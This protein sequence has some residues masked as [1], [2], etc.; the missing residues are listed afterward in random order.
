MFAVQPFC[1]IAS[2]PVA[3][4]RVHGTRVIPEKETV[5]QLLKKFSPGN[6]I[7]NFITVITRA[8]HFPLS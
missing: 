5:D 4:N 3:V 1:V 7:R 8:H 6:G 2:F